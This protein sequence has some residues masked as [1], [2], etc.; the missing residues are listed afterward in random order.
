MDVRREIAKT[1]EVPRHAGGAVQRLHS[2]ADLQAA[3]SA[4]DLRFKAYS[5]VLTVVSIQLC[6]HM[7][8]SRLQQPD[9]VPDMP[10]DITEIQHVPRNLHVSRCLH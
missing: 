7:H 2:A 5:C 10:I 4:A 1:F 9:I 8:V 6:A 3:A